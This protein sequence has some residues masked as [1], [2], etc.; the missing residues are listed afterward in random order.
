MHGDSRCQTRVVQNQL[1]IGRQAVAPRQFR[2]PRQQERR[3]PLAMH[4]LLLRFVQRLGNGRIDAL[5]RHGKRSTP[6]LL[7]RVAELTGGDSLATNIQLVL[8]NA[9]LAAAI[10]VHYGQ[11]GGYDDAVMA[12]NVRL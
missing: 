7:A 9:R 5:A 4:T 2:H 10:A 8:N 11:L 6:F 3:G 1:N 12:R